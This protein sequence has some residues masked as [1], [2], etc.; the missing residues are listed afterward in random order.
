MD[1]ELERVDTVHRAG[2]APEID[3]VGPPDPIVILVLRRRGGESVAGRC[4]LPGHHP[5]SIAIVAFERD[6]GYTGRLELGAQVDEVVEL[7]VADRAPVGED[8][9]QDDRAPAQKF[10]QAPA[11][12]VRV[13]ELEVDGRSPDSYGPEGGLVERRIATG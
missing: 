12:A 10:E 1:H 4:F 11:S 6:D 2:D 3:E 5:A 13:I 8:P 9:D 7:M